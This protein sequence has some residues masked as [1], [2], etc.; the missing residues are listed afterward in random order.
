MD[1]TTRLQTA[2]VELFR[3]LVVE[4][5][6]WLVTLRFGATLLDM[7][8]AASVPQAAA[9][10]G[11]ASDFLLLISALSI[12]AAVPAIGLAWTSKIARYSY[13]ASLIVILS[14]F[15]ALFLFSPAL[16]GDPGPGAGRAIRLVVTGL[17]SILAFVGLFGFYRQS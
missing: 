17:P 13:I 14:G 15:A 10:F 16:L 7:V 11:E 1:N 2:P 3:S 4:G 5:Y 8:Y 9:G 12:F 6:T